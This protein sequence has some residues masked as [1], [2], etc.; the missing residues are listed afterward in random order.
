MVLLV[1]ISCVMQPQYLRGLLTN[2]FDVF[3]VNPNEQ[4][5]SIG[6]QFA[7]W[8][9]NCIVPAIGIFIMV[10]Q[11]VVEG[12]SLFRWLILMSLLV[13]AFR[14]LA[15]VMV[16]Y[17]FRLGKQMGMAYLRYYSLRS[18]FTFVLFVIMLLASY[19]SPHTAWIVILVIASVVYLVTLGM[20]W[21]RLFCS[22]PIDIA[23]LLLYML[24]VELLPAV[25]L[26]EAGRQL[27]FMHIA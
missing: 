3:S 17:T 25:L 19:T 27:Y 21:G 13:D 14:L 24:T 2:S 26:W 7:Q 12:T 4:I 8:L 5:P 11:E 18:L 23:G 10:E 6:S 9:F 22:S 20:Q 16:Q 15:A 1:W